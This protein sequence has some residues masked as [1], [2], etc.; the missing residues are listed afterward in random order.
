MGFGNGFGLRPICFSANRWQNIIAAQFKGLWYVQN[1]I[2]LLGYIISLTSIT[3]PNIFILI[4]LTNSPMSLLKWV[5][6]ISLS[7]DWGRT[8]CNQEN[9][10]LKVSKERWIIKIDVSGKT[11]Q[12]N[13]HC[14][15]PM[16]N[17]NVLFAMKRLLF[18]NNEIL[19]IIMNLSIALSK[20]TFPH[21]QRL[22]RCRKL[23]ATRPSLNETTEP[24]PLKA[25]L[26]FNIFRKWKARTK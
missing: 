11:G 15:S 26:V 13:R 5:F 12:I 18:A 2:W 25:A 9:V 19:D 22:D 7:I 14:I 23:L 21:R 24:H 8:A 16:S 17:Q 4:T 1:C 3:Y 10:A 20:C 6:Y